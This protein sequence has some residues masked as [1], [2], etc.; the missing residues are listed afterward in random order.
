MR[1]KREII[2][3]EIIFITESTTYIDLASVSLVACEKSKR[4]DDQERQKKIS[5]KSTKTHK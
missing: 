3:N 1:K 4:D 2:A 5:I